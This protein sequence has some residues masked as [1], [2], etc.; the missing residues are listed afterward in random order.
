MKIN[1]L[2][3]GRVVFEIIKIVGAAIFGKEML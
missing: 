3:V 2:K 1:W